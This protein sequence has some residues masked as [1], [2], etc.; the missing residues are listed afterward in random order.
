MANL[1]RFTLDTSAVLAFRG[2]E[3]GAARV[4]Q[5]LRAVRAGKVEIF[6]SF[7]TRMEVLYRVTK[8]EGQAA[9]D[10]SIRLLDSVALEWVSCDPQILSL[11]ASIKAH[12]GLSVADA[13]IA[14]TAKATDSILLHRDPEFRA[15]KDL[16]QEFLT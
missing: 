6:A 2:D 5:L 14:A 8:D 16:A 9:A 15:L 13:W 3:T 12:G 7:M 1:G 4:E 10:D 11:A